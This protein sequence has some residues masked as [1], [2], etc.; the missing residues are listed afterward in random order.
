LIAIG[1]GKSSQQKADHLKM[2]G[3]DSEI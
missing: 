2:G 3:F 1:L